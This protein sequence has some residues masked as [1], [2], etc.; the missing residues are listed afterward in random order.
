MISASSQGDFAA[1][2]L[3]PSRGIP[4]GLKDS[5]DGSAAHRFAVHRNNF[6][7]TLIDALAEA[8]PVTQALVGT[9]FFRAMARERILTDSPSS[10]VLI[11]Y[12]AGL[13]D[14]I[15][16]FP[17]A[18]AVAYLADV[19]RIEALRIQAYHAADAA[20]VSETTYRSLLTAPARLAATRLELHP[21]CH[22][23]RADH[24]A[25]SI[26]QAHQ[27]PPAVRDAKLADIDATRPEEILITR[28][29][30]DVLVTALPAGT[31]A[32]LDALR[33][34]HPLGTALQHAYALNEH[35][36]AGALFTT[37]MRYH[38][39]TGINAPSEESP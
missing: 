33:A 16:R 9:T 24:A 1:A 28:P 20:P 35:L 3:E 12:A 13:P 17:P 25:Y 8:F 36:D 27:E 21:A 10:P 34:G 39:V 23:F 11:D 38:L 31:T 22:W 6:V 19:A 26:W 29:A 2:L 4:A 7:V 5:P 37:L 14:F 15:A 30:L 18:G 32:W